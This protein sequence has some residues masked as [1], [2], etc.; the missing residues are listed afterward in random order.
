[1]TK[2][3][4]Y[5][6][7]DKDGSL[8][9][10]GVAK[11]LHA[12]TSQHSDAS[13]WFDQVSTT[14]VQYFASRKEALDA[15]AVA[16]RAERPKHNKQHNPDG[17]VSRLFASIGRECLA[18]RVG[19]GLTAISNAS[20]RDSIPA[21]WFIV[22]K[23]MCGE[24]GIDCPEGLFSFAVDRG[25]I[26]VDPL[27]SVVLD[28]CAKSEIAETTFGIRALGDPRFVFNLKSGREPRSKTVQ[29]VM[30]FIATGKTWDDVRRPRQEAGE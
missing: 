17:D 30:D 14:E 25:D 9:Y 19:V 11:D 6:H 5:R 29:R 3:A 15:E 12:R 10:I 13:A 16:I 22:V 27:L 28:H 23:N 7:F 4:L 8:L 26:D 1:M 2:T 18:R 24:C 20:V 21:S